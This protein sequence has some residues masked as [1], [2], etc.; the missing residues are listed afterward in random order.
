ME[1]LSALPA[2]CE[3]QSRSGRAFRHTQG[4]PGFRTIQVCAKDLPAHPWQ[5]GG[6]KTDPQ[7]LVSAYAG[8]AEKAGEDPRCST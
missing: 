5:A 2:H 4:A 6:A 3:I 7:R 1:E 8:D